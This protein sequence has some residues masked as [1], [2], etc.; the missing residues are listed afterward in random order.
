MANEQ[1]EELPEG[2][3]SSGLLRYRKRGGRGAVGVSF[4]IVMWPRTWYC[5]IAT[6]IYFRDGVKA[7]EKGLATRRVGQDNS[8]G[9]AGKE[10]KYRTDEKAKKVG[11][12]T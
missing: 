10:C 1:P 11:G 8:R 3:R 6:G 9:R 4:S 7:L 2:K 12:A 5:E